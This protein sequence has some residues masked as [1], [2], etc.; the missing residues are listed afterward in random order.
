MERKI[1]DRQISKE[2]ET[3]GVKSLVGDEDEEDPPPKDFDRN[4]IKNMSD[5]IPGCVMDRWGKCFTKDPTQHDMLQ[6]E[7]IEL[8]LSKAEEENAELR[9]QP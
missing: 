6:L 9:Y 4:A 2:V 7:E 5:P 1:Y 3:D 8:T